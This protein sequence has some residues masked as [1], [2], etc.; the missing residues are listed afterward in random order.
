[1][2]NIDVDPVEIPYPV[3]TRLGVREA[4]WAELVS[5]ARKAD[6]EQRR[7]GAAR[8]EQL[9][10]L[11]GRREGLLTAYAMLTAQSE[12]DVHEQLGEALYG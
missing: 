3:L 4:L 7:A 12:M 8:G 10:W 5:A 2:T 1:M 11:Q 6:Y 9:L